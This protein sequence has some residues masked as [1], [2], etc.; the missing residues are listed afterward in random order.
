MITDQTLR[1]DEV[2]VDE[3]YENCTFLTSNERLRFSDVTF[4]RC[5]FEQDDLADSEWLDCEFQYINWS[6]K[7]IQRSL[8]YRC[9]F[10]NCQLVGTDFFEN[11]WRDNE[12]V[13]SKA[14]YLNLAAAKLNNCN[15]SDTDLKDASFQDGEIT[16]VLKFKGGDLSHADFTETPLKQIDFSKSYF[17]SIL[18]TP[19]LLRGCKINSLQ[20]SVMLSMLGAKIVE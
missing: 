16:K 12:V 14:D 17:E 5:T 10:E 11:N 18:F 4:R 20:A 7:Q 3:T 13:E 6:N 19:G 2:R 9:K 8:L 1:L 15:F